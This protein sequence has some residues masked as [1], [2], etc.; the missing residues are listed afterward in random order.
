M[1][2]QFT[3]IGGYAGLVGACAMFA[4]DM[5]FYGHL[6]TGGDALTSSLQGRRLRRWNRSVGF[7]VRVSATAANF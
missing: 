3:R 5:L 1:N 7:G 4:G 6:G 2:G